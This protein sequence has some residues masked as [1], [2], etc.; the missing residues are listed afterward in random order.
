M[1]FKKISLLIS[2]VICTNTVALGTSSVS[3]DRVDINYCVENELARSNLDNDLDIS[4]T[5][6]MFVNMLNCY[7]NKIIDLIDTYIPK[8]NFEDVSK[9]YNSIN[10]AYNNSITHGL[11]KYRFGIG[12]PITKEDALT[13]LYRLAN[14]LGIDTSISKDISI[15]TYDDAD[16]VSD[17]AVNPLKWSIDKNIIDKKEDTISPKN[18]L[19]KEEIVQILNSFN[20]ILKSTNSLSFNIV[21]DELSSIDI[22]TSFGFDY[23]VESEKDIRDLI[24]TINNINFKSIEPRDDFK[25][26][27]LSIS[28]NF[29]DLSG[30]FDINIYSSYILSGGYKYNVVDEDVDSLKE[31]VEKWD[32]NYKK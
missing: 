6:E 13:M 11:S 19:T 17:Y 2:L 26:D 12:N 25:S 30:F 24:D 3:Q 9:D 21:A 7:S 32:T 14:R 10:W 28:L 5:R 23:S 29:D 15:D 31:I 1:K 4:I 8:N 18:G 16:K 27:P 22:K 20:E